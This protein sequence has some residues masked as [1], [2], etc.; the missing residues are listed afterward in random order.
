M[1]KEFDY[2]ELDE[3]LKK[4]RNQ[5]EK[6]DAFE[7]LEPPKTREQMRA[8]TVEENSEPKEN[9]KAKV[10]IPKV[11]IDSGVVKANFKTRL[12]PRV[13]AVLKRIF[14]R[15]LLIAL[16]CV[17]VAAGLVFGGIKLHE[18][19]KVA[20]LK[21][22]IEKYD[23]EYP[24]GI[25]EE[26]C[27]AYGRDRTFAGEIVF[28]DSGRAFSVS[29][30]NN[31]GEGHMDFGGTV[32]K[33]QHL[34]SVSLDTNPLEK[35]YS[36][37][38]SFVASKQ[39]VVFRTLFGDEEYRVVA[40]YFANTNPDNDNGYVFPYNAWGNMTK[41]SFNSY[42]DRVKTRSLYHTTAELHY[43]DSYLSV[44]MPT[45]SE[46]DSRFVVLC[47]KVRDGEEFSKITSTRKN[48]R[49]RKTQ[50]WYDE[51]GEK[52]P[53][54]LAAKWYPEIYTDA[55]LTKTKQLSAKDFEV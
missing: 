51:N 21:P 49:I 46:V 17:A 8:E 12:L 31:K 37:A 26:F 28:D 27:D 35:Y 42:I 50:A 55:K 54:Y 22:Y 11:K 9:K 1:S 47:V 4:V 18:Y 38:K 24:V 41:K 3:I 19:S 13:T 39:R 5:N 40:A 20:Y 48:T 10:N 44:N 45:D 23:I 14:T 16:G 34:R 6:D 33:E 25:R 7:P 30:S 32:L 15:Q 29:G 53:Y 52:N 43:S 36:N 2:N